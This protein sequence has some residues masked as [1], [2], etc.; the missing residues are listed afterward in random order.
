MPAVLPCDARGGAQKGPAIIYGSLNHSS[1]RI[2]KAAA[3]EWAYLV[4][5]DKADFEE[6]KCRQSERL[7]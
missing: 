6:E 4:V 7:R 1:R 3:Q 5:C 2:S